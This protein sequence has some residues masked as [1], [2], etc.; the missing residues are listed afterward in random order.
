MFEDPSAQLK[1]IRST[2]VGLVTP[3]FGYLGP[4]GV[5]KF[6][7]SLTDLDVEYLYHVLL[8]ENARRVHVPY[9]QPSPN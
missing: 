9:Q 5:P 6:R 4:Y 2:Q 7:E 3:T 1:C 8:L